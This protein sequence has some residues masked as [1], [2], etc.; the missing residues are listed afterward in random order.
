MT[1]RFNGRVHFANGDPAPDVSVRMYDQDAPGKQD[2]DLTVAP[3]LSNEDGYFTLTYEPLRYLDFHTRHTPA[4][5]FQP[6]EAPSETDAVRIPDLADI[7][8]PYLKFNYTCNGLIY[9]HTASMGIFKTSFYLPENPPVE[10]LPS[11]HGF[12]F[13]NSFPGYFLPFSPPEF[14][15]SPKV[16]PSYGLC[17]GMCAAANDFA[18]ARRRVPTSTS[19]PGQ[20]TRLHR[21]LFRRQI[22]SLGGL[23]QEAVKVAQWTSLPDGTLVGTFRRTADEFDRL[24][25][26]LDRKNL[27]ILALI[28]AQAASLAD[29]SQVIFDNHQVLAYAYHREVDAYSIDIYDPNIPGRDDVSLRCEPVDLGAENTP[30]SLHQVSGLK[31]TQ[32]LAGVPTKKVRGFFNMPYQ[33]VKPP[34]GL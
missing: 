12:R 26:K 28:Y 32:L 22:D 15:S 27:V 14:I 25:V 9:S 34:K 20:G 3:G 23:G 18:L 4:L 31:T 24:R 8:L 17:G 29:L 19:V 21:Y 11:T 5:A 6:G 30:E 16:P 13:V 7:Y 10:F 2:D 33:P 1:L